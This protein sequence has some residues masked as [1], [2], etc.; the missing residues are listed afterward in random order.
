MKL[1]KSLKKKDKETY[2]E[3]CSL[4]WGCV[5]VDVDW[6]MGTKFYQEAERKYLAKKQ[7]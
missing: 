2:V 1:S 7:N 6:A 4:I 3:I 5:P